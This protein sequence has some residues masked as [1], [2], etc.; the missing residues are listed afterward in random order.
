M[1]YFA[2]KERL[3]YEVRESE[4]L[5]NETENE[6]LME[7]ERAMTVARENEKL[8]AQLEE[9]ENYKVYKITI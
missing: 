3:L 5:L 8:K 1:V 4:W 6:L 7:E 9:G 2:E